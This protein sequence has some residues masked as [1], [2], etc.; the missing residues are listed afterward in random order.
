MQLTKWVNE[1]IW[2]SK[3]KSFIT[4]VQGHS[5]STF[6]NFFPQK[7]LGPLKLNFMWILHG[8]G[9]RKFVQ[10]VQVTWP[11][12]PPCP[13]MVKTL[14]NLLLWNQKADDLE[15]WYAALGTGVLWSVFKWWPWLT[16]TYFTTR[17]NFAP[18]AFVWEEGKTMDFSV[19]I[20]VYDI[21]AG[22]C[23]QLNK[24]MNLYEYQCHSLTL[25]QISQI[26]CF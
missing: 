14:K 10:M 23:S 16:M 18:Y 12:W 3:V 9:Q 26:Q 8:M 1:L 15:S 11:G 17:S 2:I 5:N 4:L 6:S 20:V 13:Y 7:L 25:V 21:R 22:R 19:T 24:Y